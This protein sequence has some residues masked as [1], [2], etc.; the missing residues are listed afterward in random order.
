MKQEEI[1]LSAYFNGVEYK[2]CFEKQV[3]DYPSSTVHSSNSSHSS[4]T[5]TN[6]HCT[7][8]FFPTQKP[9]RK[10]IANAIKDKTVQIMSQ[11]SNTSGKLYT[12][13]PTSTGDGQSLLV[14]QY[15]E[16]VTNPQP[17]RKKFRMK[18]F[19]WENFMS[20]G[21]KRTKVALEGA[22]PYTK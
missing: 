9:K 5:I 1:D 13:K 17:F 19:R 2:R 16:P 3:E 18:V 15:N 11:S 21:F 12:K 6:I 4:S 8:N 22:N 10:T 20:M 7:A 14:E